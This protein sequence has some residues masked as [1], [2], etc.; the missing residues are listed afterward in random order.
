MT[1]ANRP[2]QI[3]EILKTVATKYS[4]DVATS[5]EAYIVDLEANQAERPAQIA[6]ILQTIDS[7]Y[8]L[9][10]GIFLEGY[11]SALEAGQQRNI[12]TDKKSKLRDPEWQY[13][14]SQKRAKQRRNRAVRK[15]YQGQLKPGI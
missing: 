10:M 5:L 6:A 13:W 14:H 15:A 3:A 4:N 8:P 11:V 9:D 1:R 2:K 7:D 12:P